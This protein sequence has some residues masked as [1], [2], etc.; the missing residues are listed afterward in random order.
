MNYEK[1]GEL[2]LNTLNYEGRFAKVVMPNLKKGKNR[3]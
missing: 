3:T 2:L 1:V